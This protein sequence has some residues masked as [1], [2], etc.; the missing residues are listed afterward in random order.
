MIEHSD[1]DWTEDF[2]HENGNYEC[3]CIY[4]KK[5]FYGHKRRVVCKKC[6]EIPSNEKEE[7]K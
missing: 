1:R 7:G 3:V 2:P 5:H 4:C 6:A